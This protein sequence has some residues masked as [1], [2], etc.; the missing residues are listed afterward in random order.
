MKS[1]ISVGFI[2]TILIMPQFGAIGYLASSGDLNVLEAV[3]ALISIPGNLV[4]TL[5]S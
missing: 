1:L 5:L 2:F 4:L 3:V